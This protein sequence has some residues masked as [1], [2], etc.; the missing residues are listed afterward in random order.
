MIL[1]PNPAFVL[2]VVASCSPTDLAAF[3]ASLEEQ[4]SRALSG[5]RGAYTSQGLQ[6]PEGLYDSAPCAPFLPD[7]IRARVSLIWSGFYLVIVD[8]R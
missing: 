5:S 4:V 2:K 7:Q 8:V 3:T 6:S 1:K